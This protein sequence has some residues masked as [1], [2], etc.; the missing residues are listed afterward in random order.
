VV[1]ESKSPFKALYGIVPE[2]LR[3]EKFWDRLS[4]AEAERLDVR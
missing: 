1:A 4:G 3:G 2:D